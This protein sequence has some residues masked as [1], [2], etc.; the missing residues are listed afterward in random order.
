M[1]IK[2]LGRSNPVFIPDVPSAG[3]DDAGIQH[4]LRYI[5]SSEKEDLTIIISHTIRDS[6]RW[7]I[8]LLCLTDHR[9][10]SVGF[11]TAYGKI[12][13]MRGGTPRFI[14]YLR[15]VTY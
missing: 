5:G 4:M 1:L 10:Q 14:T 3:V 12:D 6:K 13:R 7:Q 9:G 8:I 11:E 2:A 15:M